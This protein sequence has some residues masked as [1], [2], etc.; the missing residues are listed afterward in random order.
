MGKGVTAERCASNMRYYV[1]PIVKANLSPRDRLYDY[2]EIWSEYVKVCTNEI[3][4]QIPDNP[5][6]QIPAGEGKATREI[7]NTLLE[8]KNSVKRTI[9]K[10]RKPDWLTIGITTVGV[11]VVSYFVI[12][13]IF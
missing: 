4:P 5:F 13:K 12:K 1:W 10:S 2:D 8:K 7:Y 11:S 3:M 9:D 6:P